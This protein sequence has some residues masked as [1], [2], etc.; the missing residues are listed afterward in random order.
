M[1][2]GQH[3]EKLLNLG[4]PMTNVTFKELGNR[5]RS[6][7]T[8]KKELYTKPSC[9]IL[10][11]S[12]PCVGMLCLLDLCCFT[13][14]PPIGIIIVENAFFASPLSKLFD[15]SVILVSIAIKYNL[16]DALLIGHFRNLTT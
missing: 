7:W 5:L 16:T 9:G 15:N 8:A 10:A 1:Q 3:C 2:A 11:A 6:R 12:G 4:E 13:D 14:L